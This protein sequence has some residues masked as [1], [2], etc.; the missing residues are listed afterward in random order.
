MVGHHPDQVVMVNVVGDS[1]YSTF[2]PNDVVAALVM[3][4]K[5]L[6]DGLWGFA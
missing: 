1:M 4:Q 2:A 5:E 6:V 3:D